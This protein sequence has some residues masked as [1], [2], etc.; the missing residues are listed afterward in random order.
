MTDKQ[1]LEAI[2]A[3]LN[4]EW[5]NPYLMQIGPLSVDPEYDIRRIIEDF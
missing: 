3:R 1:K 4:G 2:I 5:D